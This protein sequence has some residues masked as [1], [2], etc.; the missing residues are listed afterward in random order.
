METNIAPFYPLMEQWLAQN[1]S[2][3]LSQLLPPERFSMMEADITNPKTIDVF[4]AHED[5]FLDAF[6]IVYQGKRAEELKKEISPWVLQHYP[7]GDAYA[8]TDMSIDEAR[9][10][11]ASDFPKDALADACD[12]WYSSAEDELTNCAFQQMRNDLCRYDDDDEIFDRYDG[13]FYDVFLDTYYIQSPEEEQTKQKFFCLLPQ[14]GKASEIAQLSLAKLISHRQHGTK[15][16]VLLDEHEAKLYRPL[17][18]MREMAKN[19]QAK[20][21]SSKETGS[22]LQEAVKTVAHELRQTEQKVK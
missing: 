13:D 17:Q 5:E 7:D 19:L 16:P 1:Y 20:G 11:L 6:T 3:K 14:S 15:M 4:L 21:Y 18:T 22:L 2:P 10:I 12:L 9:N 8:I